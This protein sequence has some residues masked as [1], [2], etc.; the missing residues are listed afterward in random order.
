MQSKA[1]IWERISRLA[2]SNGCRVFDIDYPSGPQGV[3]RV[4]LCNHEGKTAGIGHDQCAAVSKALCDF[5]D[6]EEIAPGDCSIE[7]STPGINRRLSRPEHFAGAVGE[8]VKV[9]VRPERDAPEQ[10][11]KRVLRGVLRGATESGLQLDD[12][13]SGSVVEVK[14]DLVREAR[15]DFKF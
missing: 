13:E 10:K 15:V 1:E 7:V 6:I 11:K 12:E 8:R 14:C 2:E 9:V 3:F 5:A 4:L